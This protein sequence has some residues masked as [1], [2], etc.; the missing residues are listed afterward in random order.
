MNVRF[1]LCHALNLTAVLGSTSLAGPQAAWHGAQFGTSPEEVKTSLK[2]FAMIDDPPNELVSS[3]DF[4][5]QV[6]DMTVPIPFSV[7]AGFDHNALTMISLTLDFTKV[8]GTPST[9]IAQGTTVDAFH[10]QIR[11]QLI[12]QYGQP[13]NSH[14]DCFRTGFSLREAACTMTWHPSGQMIKYAW[15]VNSRLVYLLVEYTP[16]RNQF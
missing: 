9:P 6:P 3:Q 10:S 8:R 11:D 14:G 15:S 1:F 12:N 2:D 7:H 5:L 13:A 16:V 4:L